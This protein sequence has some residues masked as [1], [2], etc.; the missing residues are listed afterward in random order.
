[1][2]LMYLVQYLG[3]EDGFISDLKHLTSAKNDPKFALFAP[4]LILS[5]QWRHFKP[6]K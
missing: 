2:H 5:P 4:I 6:L 1:M 3:H